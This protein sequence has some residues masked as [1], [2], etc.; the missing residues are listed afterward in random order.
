MQKG[1]P[2]KKYSQAARLHDIIRL[3]EA[4]HGITIEELAEESGVNRRTIHR[5]LNAIQE[6]GYPLVSDWVNGSKAYRFLTRFKDVPPVNFTLQ[7][8]MTLSFLRSQL[9]FLKGTSFHDDMEAIF[10]KVNSVLPPRYAA[11]MDRIAR[12]SLPLLQGGRDYS[13]IAE[14]L[15]DIRDAL[16]YQYRLI[17]NY[18]APA[19]KSAEEY[20]VDPYTLIYNKGGLYLL[21]YAHNRRA[22]R[23][24][25]AER[26]KTVMVTRE[27][28]EMPEDFRP[29]EQFKS[30][31][32]MVEEAPI[33]VSI[34]FSPTIAHAIS[35]RLWHPTQTIRREKDGSIILSF[36]AGGRMEMV[37]W[38][39]SYGRHA[40]VLEP[41]DLREEMQATVVGMAALYGAGPTSP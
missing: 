10:H 36:R 37:A 5:D 9:D 4:R 14:Q 41:A 19:K 30:A 2:A 8:L 21:G 28:F 38:I 22:I 16:L 26:I 25:A 11:H 3:I 12:V 18:W 35:D 39:L 15:K 7:E 27:R 24:F 32:G 29:E 17:I 40:E 1:K 23:T 20:Q 6:A 31:F 13:G 34:R 33:S